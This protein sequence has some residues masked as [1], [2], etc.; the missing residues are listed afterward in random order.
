MT[1]HRSRPA[2]TAGSYLVLTVL[3][4]VF[5]A[6]IAYLVIGSFKPSSEVI[7]GVG[8]FVP[9]DLSLDNYTGM[10]GRFS[11]PATGYFADFFL[12]SLLVTTG[13]VLL[14]L[15]VN[16][17]AAYSLA[18]LRWG[19]RDA[20]ML[21]VVA[22][23]I[24]P[25]EAIA[26]PLF[27][28]LNEHRNTYYIQILPFVA[29]AFSIYLFYSFFIGLPKEI[30]EAARLDGA[31]VWRTY[32]RIIVPMSK[33]VFA[34]VAILSF[35]TTWGSFLWPVMMV[36]QPQKRPLPLAIAVFQGQPPYDWGQ[37]FAF[38]VLMVLPVL[39]VFLLFQ[40]WFVQSLAS[41]GLKG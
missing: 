8:G 31:G 41:S 3:A 1:T 11:S 26:V 7:D 33:P 13:V 14:G 16:S 25:F 40:R 2:R 4:L 34:T 35:L 36:D 22:L 10:L 24:L 38:G 15:L 37:I 28:A 19:G 6:P 23:T 9:R 20:V 30:E 29:S 18:R 39:V 17:M 12:T 21:G 27:Y 5:V 32:L